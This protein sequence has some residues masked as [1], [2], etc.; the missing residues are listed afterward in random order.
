MPLLLLEGMLPLLLLVLVCLTWVTLSVAGCCLL[1]APL[2]A[3]KRRAASWCWCRKGFLYWGKGKGRES[4]AREREEVDEILLLLAIGKKQKRRRHQQKEE[5]EEEE[6]DVD[7]LFLCRGVL[8]R[9]VMVD[10]VL[11][12]SRTRPI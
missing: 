10:M 5:E 12:A 9:V 7:L 11:D 8:V 4:G 1:V 2:A 3:S 6:E